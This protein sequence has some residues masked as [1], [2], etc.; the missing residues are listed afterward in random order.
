MLDVNYAMN[1]PEED[2]F[3]DHLEPPDPVLSENEFMNDGHDTDVEE[4]MSAQY[5]KLKI[6]D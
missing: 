2:K 1:L 5:S 4:F 6:A 3:E